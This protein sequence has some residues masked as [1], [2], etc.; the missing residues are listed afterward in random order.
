MGERYSEPVV[1]EEAIAAFAAALEEYRED[2]SPLLWAQTRASQAEAML[3]L[4][5]RNKD[6]ALAQQALTQLM[7]A[8]QTAGQATNGGAVAADLQKRLG[9]AGAT[10]TKLIGG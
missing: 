9:A 8:T 6:K 7:T 1:I 2:R 4:A 10:A 5:R 3:Q